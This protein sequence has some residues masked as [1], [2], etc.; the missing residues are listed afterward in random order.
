MCGIMRVAPRQNQFRMLIAFELCQCQH[1]KR[2][3]HNERA[4]NYL[5]MCK[6]HTSFTNQQY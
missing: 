5:G 4:E 1:Q 3:V 2:I 6:I